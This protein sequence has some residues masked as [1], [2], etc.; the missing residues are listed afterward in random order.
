[1][2]CTQYIVH[3]HNA[4]VL[5]GSLLNPQR[6]FVFTRGF[7]P[8]HMNL[9]RACRRQVIRNKFGGDKLRMASLAPVPTAALGESL[10]SG[11]SFLI[12]VSP[13]T[14]EVRACSR[15]PV[16]PCPVQ[17][18]DSSCPVTQALEK[19]WETSKQLQVDRR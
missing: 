15:A 1:M 10:K 12:D 18:R 6:T 11:N 17:T 4:K 13:A 3:S 14:H 8:A 5:S 16:E 7:S 9:Q 2:C 19:L